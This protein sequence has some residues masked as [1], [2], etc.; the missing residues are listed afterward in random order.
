MSRHTILMVEDSE[1]D[2][3]LIRRRLDEQL[4]G[5]FNLARCKTMTDAKKF[6]EENKDD[7]RLVLL[8]LGLPDTNGGEDTF[9]N[10]RKYCAETPVVILTTVEDHDLAVSLVRNGAQ[11]FVNKSLLIEKPEL[12]RDAVDFA[13]SRQKVID[14]MSEKAMAALAEKESVISWMSGGYTVQK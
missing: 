13:V 11:N 6:I 8:D 10:I 4:G 3:T 9:G 14:E 7:I 2:A 12:L 1:D 5:H